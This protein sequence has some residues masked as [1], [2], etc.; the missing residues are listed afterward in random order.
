[1]IGRKVGGIVTA[2]TSRNNNAT[3]I[4]AFVATE[5]G[6][7]LCGDDMHCSCRELFTWQT[8]G[9]RWSGFIR[10]SGKTHMLFGASTLPAEHHN[11]SPTSRYGERSTFGRTLNWSSFSCAASC[12]FVQHLVQQ[13]PLVRNVCHHRTKDGVFARATHIAERHVGKT[14]FYVFFSTNPSNWKRVALN[15]ISNGNSQTRAL[16]LMGARQ[17]GHDPRRTDFGEFRVANGR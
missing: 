6:I 17:N 3:D 16:L 8:Y 1:M 9:Q 2:R 5:F 14:T 11:F 7:A 12:V 10:S 15:R 4:P 13:R